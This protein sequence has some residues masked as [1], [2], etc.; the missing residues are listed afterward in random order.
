MM[1]MTD[2]NTDPASL[3]RLADENRNLLEGYG[4]YARWGAIV[5]DTLRA[6]AAEKEA[7]ATL[8]EAAEQARAALKPFYDGYLSSQWHNVDGESMKRMYVAQTAGNRARDALTILDTT[9]ET[10]NDTSRN[11]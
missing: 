3:R 11:L 5:A 2:V 6:L 9:L 4:D 1:T 7:I 8:T 10:R